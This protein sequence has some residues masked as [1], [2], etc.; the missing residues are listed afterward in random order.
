MFIK[1]C[2]ILIHVKLQM[3]FVTKGQLETTSLLS[4]TFDPSEPHPKVAASWWHQGN[5]IRK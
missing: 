5:R 4:L 2:T 1:S 3:I